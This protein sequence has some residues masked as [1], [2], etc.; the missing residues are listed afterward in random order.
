MVVVVLVAGDGHQFLAEPDVPHAHAPAGAVG[1]EYVRE[2]RHLVY[3]PARA[4]CL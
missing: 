2:Y 4:H 1:V 3:V